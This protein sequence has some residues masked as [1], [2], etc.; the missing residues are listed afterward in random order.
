MKPEPS[1][2]V[3]NSSISPSPKKR[4]K[5]SLNGLSLGRSGISNPLGSCGR[6][7]DVCFWVV[8]MLTTAVRCS[9]TSSVKSGRLRDAAALADASPSSTTT[10]PMVRSASFNFFIKPPLWG[11]FAAAPGGHAAPAASRKRNIITGFLAPA[12][13]APRA[14]AGALTGA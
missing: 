1:D 11:V 4:R 9:A 3:L 14:G 7:P 13:A 2:W 5:N 10:V 8:L 12:V 6:A